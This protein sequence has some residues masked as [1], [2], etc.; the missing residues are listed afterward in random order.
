M[1]IRFRKSIKIAKGVRLNLN[2]RSVGL[3]IGGRGARYTINSKGRRTSTIGIPGTGLSFSQTSLRHKPVPTARPKKRR[4]VE[5]SVEHRVL[6]LDPNAPMGAR[7][8]PLQ[9][10]MNYANQFLKEKVPKEYY[11]RYTS[12]K[13]LLTWVCVITLFLSIT[14]P[15]MLLVF[16][17]GIYFKCFWNR[18]DDIYIKKYRSA[19]D[20][21][22]IQNFQRCS[23]DVNFLIENGFVNNELKNTR[24]EC[25]L[26]L[27]GTSEGEL[28]SEVSVIRDLIRNMEN[29]SVDYILSHYDAVVNKVCEL[30]FSVVQ[31]NKKYLIS[32]IHNRKLKVV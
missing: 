18:D 30:K 4:S 13:K 29:G 20:A 31:Y 2:K 16:A 23:D 24:R 12:I 32:K 1:A 27:R 19:Y 21:L 25:F 28:D 8:A 26:R 22:I 5:H 11:G 10:Q 6:V 3:S 17:T 9:V 7:K 15:L 14:Y